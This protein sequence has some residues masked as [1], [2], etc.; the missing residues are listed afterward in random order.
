MSQVK[1]I[2]ASEL[3]LPPGI[4]PKKLLAGRYGIVFRTNIV[5]N[6]FTNEIEHVDYFVDSTGDTIRVFND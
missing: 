1:T 6:S 3:R 4:W 5:R 2:E